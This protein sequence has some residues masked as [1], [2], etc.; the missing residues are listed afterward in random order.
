[1]ILGDDRY[2]LALRNYEAAQH[3]LHLTRAIGAPLYRGFLHLFEV[4]V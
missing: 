1:M 4:T 2:Y 3:P